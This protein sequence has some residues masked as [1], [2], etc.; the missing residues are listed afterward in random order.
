MT[1]AKREITQST[2]KKT[3]YGVLHKKLW[4]V[5]VIDQIKVGIIKYFKPTQMCFKT[6]Y[7]HFKKYYRAKWKILCYIM[8]LRSQ[9][10][11]K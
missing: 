10:M 8:I 4:Q 2:Y 11:H 3:K 7:Q 5:K 6:T 9:E 1:I